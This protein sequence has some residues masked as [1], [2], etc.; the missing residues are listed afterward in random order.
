[1]KIL[2]LTSTNVKRIKAVDITPDPSG[3]VVVVGGR[4]GQGKSSV[5]DS[6][7]YALGGKDVICQE[8][9]RR[10]EER[11]E[12]TC[13]LGDFIVTRSFTPDGGGQLTLQSKD[14]AHYNMPQTRLDD[15]VGRLSFDP[16]EFSR[17]TPALQA[18]TLRALVGLD[19]TQLDAERDRVF[20]QRTLLNRDGK[21][22]AARYDALPPAHAGVPDAEVSAP[23]ILARLD[24]ATQTQSAVQMARHGHAAAL[25]N[26]ERAQADIA[27]VVREAEAGVL[28]RGEDVNRIKAE[29]E[30]LTAQLEQKSRELGSAIEAH[31]VETEAAAAR[32]KEA[33]DIAEASARRASDAEA[34]VQEVAAAAID[35]EAVKEELKVLGEVNRR[36]RENAARQAMAAELKQKRAESQALTDKLDEIARRREQTIAGAAFPVPGLGFNEAGVVTL[37]GLPFDQASSAEQLRVSVAMGLALNPKL[38]TLLVR[39]GSLLDDDSMQVLHEMAATADAQLWIERVEQDGATVII[40]DGS[41]VPPAVVA[42]AKAS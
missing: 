2:R 4:N 32:M 29:I 22:L 35:P 25:S 27:R 16:L 13:D 9:V 12:V 10:G 41:V 36:V 8:P 19:F 33:G 37:N 30:Q 31:R 21:A 14:G 28:H 5:L 26:A 6:I 17:M 15:I 34:K 1:M 40:E 3:N 20:A 23:D 7:M 18:E 42:E 38:R 24:H 39:D 11:A